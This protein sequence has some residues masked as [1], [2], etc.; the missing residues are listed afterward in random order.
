MDRFNGIHDPQGLLWRQYVSKAGQICLDWRT[1]EGGKINKTE[2]AKSRPRK[3]QNS[4]KN[5]N[6]ARAHKHPLGIG[7]KA[8][9]KKTQ[10]ISMKFF[11]TFFSH[12]C[13][14]G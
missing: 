5:I 3:E 10:K 9:M 4:T 6:Y 7:K 1:E 11:L 13:F 14:L 2:N 12:A 8:V